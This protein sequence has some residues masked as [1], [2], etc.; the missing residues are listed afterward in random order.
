VKDLS[1]KPNKV[2]KTLQEISFQNTAPGIRYTSEGHCLIISKSADLIAV[3]D[4][5]PSSLEYCVVLNDPCPI[6][7]AEILTHQVIPYFDNIKEFRIEGFLGNFNMEI[8]QNSNF[9]NI[10]S[11]MNPAPAKFDLILDLALPATISQTIPP[12]GY[13]NCSVK[14]TQSQSVIAQLADWVGEFE[15]PRFFSF[16]AGLCAHQNSSIIGCEQCLSACAAEAIQSQAG[17]IQI[18]PYLCQGCGDCASSCPSGAI[19]YAYP[20]P[21]ETLEKFRKIIQ[22]FIATHK[23]PPSILLH[24]SGSGSQWLANHSSQLDSEILPFEVETLGSVGLEMWLAMFAFGASRV[25]LLD[26]GALNPQTDFVLTHQL[27]FANEI[28]SGIGF[29]DDRLVRSKGGREDDIFT[30]AHPTAVEPSF[31]PATFSGIDDK[32]TIL[33]LSVKHLATHAARLT[34]T[35]PLSAGAP[36]GEIIVDSQRCTLCM[37]CVSVCPEA[38]LTDG[39]DQPR[40]SFI[41]ANCVQCTIC[42]QAC[43]ENAIT[44]NPRYILDTTHSRKPR[45]LHQEQAF[46]CIECDKPFAT[47]KM[48]DTITEKLKSHSMFQ[49]D[50]KR[51]IMM[52]E[53]CRIRNQFE[54][55]LTKT[56][57]PTDS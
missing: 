12:P 3:I 53:E 50:N 49:N 1:S 47:Q 40:L 55:P 34:D 27:Q 8:L 51:R 57:T 29:P 19:R 28:L 39:Y 2:Q 6:T 36:F 15:K 9:V 42:S 20:T 31:R 25:V 38:A 18:D 54:N 24:D 56:S 33:R 23:K 22:N 41:E 11:L 16:T 32:R 52:C 5:L 43:P 17:K 44:L 7:L 21:K 10:S 14:D 35:I 30:S 37:S 26:T 45:T 48:I 4:W 13:F 46:H